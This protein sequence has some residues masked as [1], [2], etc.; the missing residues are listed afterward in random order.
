MCKE[1]SQITFILSNE[2]EKKLF[3]D[4]INFHK[5]THCSREV[6]NSWLHNILYVSSILHL[7][8]IEKKEGKGNEL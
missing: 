7:F 6:I 3:H 1:A 4:A 2:K 8:K 5:K